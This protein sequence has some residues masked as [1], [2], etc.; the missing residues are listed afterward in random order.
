[1]Y[2]YIEILVSNEHKRASHEFT[3]LM[4]ALSPQLLTARTILMLEHTR[5]HTQALSLSLTHT[6]TLPPSLPLS[7]SHTIS[8]S[9]GSLGCGEDRW[10]DKTAVS[11]TAVSRTI[12]NG[13]GHEICKSVYTFV[14]MQTT[15]R[16]SGEY[17]IFDLFIRNVK[18]L[19]T[20][21]TALRCQATAFNSLLLWLIFCFCSACS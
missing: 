11:K 18:Y 8:I 17:T 20:Y 12:F 9:L 15:R 2:I 3:L 21:A 1:M 14:I 4:G 10:E 13:V 7:L 6:H 5:A 19:G 16:N